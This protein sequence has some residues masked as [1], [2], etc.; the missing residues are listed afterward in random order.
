MTDCVYPSCG[1]GQ[2]EPALAEDG[3]FC[4]PCRHRFRRTITWLVHDWIH[5]RSTLPKPTGGNLDNR[6]KRSSPTPGH[7][8]EWASDTTRRIA[9]TLNEIDD[10]LCDHLNRLPP[11]PPQASELARVR[12]AYGTLTRNFDALVLAP[13]AEPAATEIHDLHRHIRT[14]LGRTNPKIH[15]PTPCPSCGLILLSRHIGL[16][17]SDRIVCENPDCDR[18]VKEEHYA[19]LVRIIL[20]ELFE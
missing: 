10:D 16:D 12:H 14:R 20:E 7:P 6:I 3:P 5:L 11:P 13:C 17:R 2:P 4:S 9:D 1:Y 19:L 15:V 8:A 18:V